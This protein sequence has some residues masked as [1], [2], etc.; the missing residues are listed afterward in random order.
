MVV[1]KE[2]KPIEKTPEQI[3]A[4]MLEEFSKES[5]GVIALAYCYAKNFEQYGEDVT[6]R[7]KN[8]A[9]QTDALNRAYAKGWE[10]GRLYEARNHKGNHHAVGCLTN[11]K[12]RDDSV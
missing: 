9:L 12:N 11:S 1:N 2:P 7:W 5:D 10:E 6:V 3:R 4:E 8:V